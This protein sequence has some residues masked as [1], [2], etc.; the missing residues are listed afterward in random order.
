MTF[1]VLSLS[2]NSQQTPAQPLFKG[3]FPRSRE[4]PLSRGSIVSYYYFPIAALPITI[5]ITT[6][7]AIIKTSIGIDTRDPDP[8]L[9][10]LQATRKI[11]NDGSEDGAQR[12]KRLWC[13]LA[14][15]STE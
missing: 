4:C 14:E 6:I 8:V 3:H 9:A 12:K 10:L 7:T 1:F 15:R 2:V 13:R 5:I 11:K